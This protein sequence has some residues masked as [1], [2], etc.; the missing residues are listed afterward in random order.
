VQSKGK[1]ARYTGNESCLKKEKSSEQ[2]IHAMKHIQS[3]KKH[4]AISSGNENAFRNHREINKC[5]TFLKRVTS[6]GN[7]KN[8]PRTINRGRRYGQNI[9]RSSIHAQ[10]SR[11]LGSIGLLTPK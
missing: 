8:Q 2:Y 6:S 1:I 10:K 5:K 7:K 9:L 4:R 11:A 3:K